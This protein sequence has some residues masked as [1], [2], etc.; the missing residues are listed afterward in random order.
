VPDADLGECVVAVVVPRAGVTLDPQVI[1]T[2]THEHLAGFKVPKHVYVV[3]EL[4]RNAM[5]K[6][7]KTKLRVRY[8]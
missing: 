8:S 3:D 1:R 4:P 2:R 7:E 6:V 5:G